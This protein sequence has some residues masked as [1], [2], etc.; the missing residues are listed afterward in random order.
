MK[1]KTNPKEH[2]EKQKQLQIQWEQLNT[3]RT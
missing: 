3:Q 2:N 1:K